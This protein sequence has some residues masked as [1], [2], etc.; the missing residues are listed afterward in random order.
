MLAAAALVLVPA[1]AHGAQKNR[2]GVELWVEAP[3]LLFPVGEG[4][5]SGIT[6]GDEPEPYVG[7][8]FLENG[9]GFGF[10]GLYGF[11]DNVAV[12][13]R[14]VQS[15]H[16]VESTDYDWDIEQ[17]YVGLRYTLVGEGSLQPFASAGV[18]RNTLE[19]SPRGDQSGEFVRLWGYGWAVSG[20]VDYLLSS[21]WVLSLRADYIAADYREALISTTEYDIDDALGGGAVGVTLAIAYRVPPF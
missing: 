6:I 7:D 11:A 14:I 18:A 19:W 20:G 13:A 1:V 8:H 12:E 21:R 10:G 5:V 17:V 16:T 4:Y 15:N 2:R 9:W 3:R